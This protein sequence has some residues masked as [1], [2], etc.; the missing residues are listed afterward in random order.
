M[1]QINLG[2]KNLLHSGEDF[3]LHYSAYR[4]LCNARYSYY[5]T[6]LAKGAMTIDDARRTAGVS[7]SFIPLVD[8]IHPGSLV[9]SLRVVCSNHIQKEEHHEQ[10]PKPKEG[11]KETTCKNHE[12][13][14]GGQKGK[15]KS[16]D[17]P[18]HL[19][20]RIEDNSITFLT[21]S[22]PR[23]GEKDSCPHGPTLAG[24]VCFTSSL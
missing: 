24:P 21:R 18:W 13:K 4:F 9:Y 2:Y 7:Y 12:R 16:E 1:S 8:Y 3:I 15:E 10:R 11:F 19:R 23:D 20:S 22:V 17:E 14:K 5:I 6:D